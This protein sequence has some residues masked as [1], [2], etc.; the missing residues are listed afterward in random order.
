LPV[1]VHCFAWDLQVLHA[2]WCL[3]IFL[4]LGTFLCSSS[5]EWYFFVFKSKRRS[6]RLLS[7]HLCVVGWLF[8][9]LYWRWCETS[10][11]LFV[12]A[13]CRVMI[14]LAVAVLQRGI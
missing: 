4:V 11:L 13:T 14:W 8:T 6:C 1:L 9:F 2:F 7:V 3:F 5:T 12:Q 10:P